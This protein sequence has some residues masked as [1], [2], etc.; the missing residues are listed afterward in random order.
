MTIIWCMFPEIW[1]L[2][3]RFFYHF[4]PFFAL[5]PSLQP[6]KLKF[7]KKKKKKNG[8]RFFILHMCPIN[9]N[10]IYDVWFLRYRD[11]LTEFF[12]HFGPFLVL[13]PKIKNNKNYDHMIC[14]S[15]DM[16]HNG[17]AEGRWK[18]RQINKQTNRKSDI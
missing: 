16:V 8:W 14:S 10:H 12:C 13:L 15:W 2:T 6:R 5:L 9:D 4:G 18:N 11:W 17:Q 1:S 3:G 7:W